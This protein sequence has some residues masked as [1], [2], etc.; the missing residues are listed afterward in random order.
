MYKLAIFEDEAIVRKNIIKKI[1]WEKH[2]FKIVGEAGNG[3]EALEVIESERPDVI[4]TDIEMPF[5]DGLELSRITREKYPEIKIII[6]TGFDEFKYAHSAIQLEVMEYILKPVSSEGLTATIE[7]VRR[8]LDIEI[9][10]KEDLQLLKQ[11][12]LESLPIIRE[13]FLNELITNRHHK[14][15]LLEKSNYL[16]MNFEESV[17][18]CSVI[19]IDKT[20]IS[21]KDFTQPDYELIKFAVLN[22]SKEILEKR[23]LGYAFSHEDHI[24]IISL[25]FENNKELIEKQLFKYLEEIRYSIDKYLKITVNIGIGNLCYTVEEI[26]GSYKNAL[27]SLNYR[28][29]VGDNRLIYIDD[30]EPQ[31]QLKIEFDENKEYILLTSIKFGDKSDI[32]NII[33]DLFSCFKDEKISFNDYQVYLL[34]MLAA[35]V[36]VSKSLMIDTKELFGQNYNLFVEMFKFNTL[37]EVKEWFK[38]ICISLMTSISERRQSSCKMYVENAKKYI[39]ENYSDSEISLNSVSKYLHI[40][41]SYFGTIFKEGTKETF[42]SYLLAVRMENA[43]NLISA[44]NLKNY[45]V[46]KKIGYTDQYYFSHSFKKYFKISPNEFRNNLNKK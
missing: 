27:M 22:T 6:L 34:E 40:S 24:V 26:S 23:N 20:S 7:K 11:S 33:E 16:N 21:R 18:I 44:S 41:P 15:E 13:N 4:I 8:Q 5:M 30:L 28:F 29:I 19:N 9:S 45:E 31:S 39:R 25:F 35:I 46:A 32:C 2:D 14:I 36:K 10:E 38:N 12:Y 1:E 42:I 37:R 17:F 3:K 43:K